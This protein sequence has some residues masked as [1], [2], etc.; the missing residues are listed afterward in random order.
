MNYEVVEQAKSFLLDKMGAP[1]RIAVIMGSGLSAVDEILVGATRL[2]YSAIPH[3]PIP[4]VA[5]HRGQVIFGRTGD[6]KAAVVFE[7]RVHLYE[8]RSHDEVTFATRVIGRLGAESLILTNA[9]GAINREFGLGRLMLITDHLNLLGVNPLRGP[10][11][12]RWGPRFID[13]TEVYSAGL[14]AKLRAA[15]D[16][17]GL[18]LVEGVYAA[19][20]GPSYETPAEI[21]MLRTLGADCV[22]MSTVPEAIVARHMGL[23]VAGISM[24][25]NIA[26][27]VSGKP[28]NHEEV[29]ET[30]LRTN[31]DLGMLLLRFFETYD[32]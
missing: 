2:D 13:Q 30:A 14:R 1:P 26:A 6:G 27:G 29:L 19:M 32:Q 25:A 5:G 16:Y 23:R 28:I 8:G 21:R 4:T 10:N 7:G 22:G 12:D 20:P 24:L 11:D 18:R 17:C 15:G 3:F 31:A 9:A